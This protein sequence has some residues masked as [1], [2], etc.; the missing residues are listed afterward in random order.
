MTQLNLGLLF[1]PRFDILP[2]RILR[3]K[4]SFVRVSSL[5]GKQTVR[6]P[7]E[8]NGKLAYLIGVIIGDGYVSR[9]SKRKSHGTGFYWRIVITGPHDY[10]VR[11]RN[12]FLGIF[13]LRGG[14]VEDRRKKNTWQLKFANLILHRFFAKV[15]GLP[16]GR[17]TTHGSWCRFDLVKRFP[18]HFLAGLLASDGYVGKRY[19]GIIQ[20][21]FRF[22]IR[23]KRFAN[24]TMHLY[25]RGPA[26]N[27]KRNGKTVGWIISIYKKEE[28]AR[29]L[30]AIASLH[31]ELKRGGK[32][33]KHNAGGFG[34]GP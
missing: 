32:R 18:L 29:L 4:Q 23:V 19:I 7:V 28:R 16:Q 17:K 15:I 5:N 12:L 24:E 22:L 25:F 13:G 10:L 3:D 26:I 34:V 27:R 31:I 2:P 30:R 14:L 11:L 6:I 21:R 9:A 1:D 33:L 8:M 20:K